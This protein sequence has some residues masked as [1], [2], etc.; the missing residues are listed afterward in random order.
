MHAGLCNWIR[1]L[2]IKKFWMVAVTGMGCV[3]SM[4]SQAQKAGSLSKAEP[5]T[6]AEVLLAPRASATIFFSGHS[7]TDNPLPEDVAR[8]ARSL[9][10]AMQW[11]QQN[12]PGSSIERR[13][14]GSIPLDAGW[15][16]YRQGKNRDGNGMDVV[17]ELRQPKTLAAG[18][19]DSLVIT[20]GHWLVDSLLKEETVRYL[21][22][23]H[24][25]LIEGNPEGR[26]F[27]Y[28][29]W[30]DISDRE[31]PGDWVAYERAAAP[32]WACV[33]ARINES[34][35][36]EGR[37]DRITPLPAASALAELV[38]SA[39]RT[40]GV[41]GLT[42]PTVAATIDRLF[43]DDVHLTRLGIYY[44]A[45]VTYAQVYGRSP[46][47]AWA[48]PEV[49]GIQATAL[50]DVAWSVVAPSLRTANNPDPK[51]CGAYL[52][53][54]FCSTYHRYMRQAYW[55]NSRST[56]YRG[57][58]TARLKQWKDSMSCE[59]AFDRS[60]RSNPFAPRRDDDRLHWFPAPQDK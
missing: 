45:L 60:D 38:E 39:M 47:G 56:Y 2:D 50:Q 3:C 33:S 11:N 35:A 36:A 57:A 34:L 59:T 31:N 29:S 51:Q 26:T 30:L 7:L 46:Q 9:G 4:S 6:S 18:R 55:G 20:E 52:R 28:S 14:R 10:T 42:G 1:V 37:K 5:A 17:R 58:V 8:I 40:P 12:I 54:S 16:G 44:M 41:P 15:A 21:R 13:T 27:F 22:H 43:K 19:Y 49:T 53:E 48:P 24:D 32:V 25:R 23:F